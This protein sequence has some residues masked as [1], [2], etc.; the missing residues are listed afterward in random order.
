MATITVLADRAEICDITE[1]NE[2]APSLASAVMLATARRRR[3]R[4]VRMI[5]GASPSAAGWA[6]TVTSYGG[7]VETLEL[8][9]SV[10]WRGASEQLPV[11]CRPL[12]VRVDLA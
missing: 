11:G 10:D 9:D 1:I 7:D 8:H 6:L 12:A 3:S 4:P 2:P 5:A